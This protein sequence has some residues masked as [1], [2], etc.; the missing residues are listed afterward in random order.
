MGFAQA[1]PRRALWPCSVGNLELAFVGHPD[2]DVRASHRHRGHGCGFIL[3]AFERGKPARSP[4]PHPGNELQ[5]CD[6]RR[7]RRLFLQFNRICSAIRAE[8]PTNSQF[9]RDGD[10]RPRSSGHRHWQC[11]PELFAWPA[12]SESGFCPR[13]ALSFGRISQFRISRGVLQLI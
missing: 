1:S 5:K 8:W 3:R 2:C 7:T 10:S 11:R 12:T 6:A 4:Q 9:G 13:K